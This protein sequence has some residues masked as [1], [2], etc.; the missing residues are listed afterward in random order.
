MCVEGIGMSTVTV[1]NKLL[2]TTCAMT[3]STNLVAR[4]RG[5]APFLPR[6][7]VLRYANMGGLDSREFA[8]QIGAVRSFTADRWCDHWNRIAAQHLRRCN[9][10]L[11][12]LGRHHGYAGVPDLDDAGSITEGISAYCRRS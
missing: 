5:A 4:W 9:A 3:R 11:R 7:F 1:W 8:E 6:L 10:A 2:V 12:G